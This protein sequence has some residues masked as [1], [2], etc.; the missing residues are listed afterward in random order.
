MKE[1]KDGN[2]TAY[3][4][5]VRY[6]EGLESG[7]TPL[8]CLHAK[9]LEEE[10]KILKKD[11]SLRQD[12]KRDRIVCPIQAERHGGAEGIRCQGLKNLSI[13]DLGNLHGYC[14][15]AEKMFDIILKK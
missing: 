13:N 3:L 8:T 10:V 6:L 2:K 15:V 12:Y 14:N 4:E 5:V 1:F 7:K 11:G 9:L